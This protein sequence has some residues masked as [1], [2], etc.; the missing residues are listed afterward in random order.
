MSTSPTDATSVAPTTAPSWSPSSSSSQA[1]S[2]AHSV[3]PI[4]APSMVPGTTQAPSYCQSVGFE[5]H[6]FVILFEFVLSLQFDCFL[7]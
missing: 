7:C 5:I 3:A 4:K 2:H 6:L 1:P